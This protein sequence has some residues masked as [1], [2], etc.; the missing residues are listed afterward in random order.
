[1]WMTSVEDSSGFSSGLQKFDESLVCSVVT[2]Q[3]ILLSVEE[4][5]FLILDC[6]YLA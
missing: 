4:P 6:F 1:M 5:M 2:I 3:F